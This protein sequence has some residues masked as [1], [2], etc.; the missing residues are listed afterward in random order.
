MKK[1]LWTAFVL[2]ATFQ[3]SFGADI[4]ES[5]KN[6]LIAELQ[7]NRFGLTRSWFNRISIDSAR[8]KI[9]DIVL[10]DQ[11][12]FVVSNDAQL[13][14]I[15]LETGATL[16][17][18][19][20][21]RPGTICMTPGVNS[22]M[23][24]V[25]A[26]ADL[27]IFDRKTGK[28]LWENKIAAVP[29]TGCVLSEKYIYQ[30]LISGRI[31][32]WPLLEALP[33]EVIDGKPDVNPAPAQLNANKDGNDQVLAE[34]KAAVD[35][36][37]AA[38]RDSIPPQKTPQFR[39]LPPSLMPLE[40]QSF[41]R[42]MVQPV[43]T[44]QTLTDEHLVWAS[45]RGEL[46]VGSIGIM[47]RDS[48]ALL[49]QIQISPAGFH[50]NGLS[51]AL[52]EQTDGRDVTSQ[53]LYL[54]QQI[55][56]KSEPADSDTES[57][58]TEDGNAED[59]NIPGMVIVGTAAGYVLAINER[60]GSIL[61]RYVASDPVY[62]RVAAVGD[63]V[64][65][66]SDTGGMHC[67][68]IRTGHKKWFTPGIVQFI[69]SSNNRVY[70]KNSLRE[71]AILDR[72]NGNVL[73]VFSAIP[74]DYLIFNVDSDRII[75]ATETGL[76]QCLHEQELIKPLKHRP[77]AIDLAEKLKKDVELAEL[78]TTPRPAIAPPRPPVSPFGGNDDTG[79]SDPFGDSEDVNPFGDSDDGFGTENT[80]DAFDTEDTD[81]G[82]GDDDDTDPFG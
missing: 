69:A 4:T 18:R 13:H 49:Y 8:F 12:L 73:S 52:A 76:F 66:C 61:W 53:P 54:P 38:L 23:V 72:T 59:E 64:Y 33:D 55:V 28:T 79:N 34:I 10:A 65:A 62:E 21:G 25:L 51:G 1:L 9:Q 67:I 35:S 78:K 70:A 36:A 2:L 14:A 17:T 26:G 31:L 32:A 39:L 71:I 7:A 45:D 40:C 6:P 29:G 60:S 19:E 81:D 43:I 63:Q 27:M 42:I 46:Y 44:D 58:N 47:T 30:P 57:E 37:R 74:F 82:F 22:R 56:K 80:N 11:T 15:D 20:L 5:R 77:N 41:G 24:G 16:W 75:L 50:F 3:C 48:F 68:D